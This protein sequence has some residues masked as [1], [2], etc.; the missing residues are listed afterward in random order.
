MTS[1]A[2]LACLLALTLASGCVSRQRPTAAYAVDAV[3]IMAGAAIV[4]SRADSCDPQDNFC[5]GWG[6]EAI[7]GTGVALVVVSTAALVTTA[8]LRRR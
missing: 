1:R 2:P 4:A 5:N 7:L 3:G 8:V 6:D